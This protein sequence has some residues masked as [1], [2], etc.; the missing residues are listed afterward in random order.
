MLVGSAFKTR[1]QKVGSVTE[2]TTFSA[3]DF[4]A[5]DGWVATGLKLG[6]IN[7]FSYLQLLNLQNRGPQFYLGTL[8]SSWDL[9]TIIT[10]K[11]GLP[12]G[13]R[14]SSL[15]SEN[16]QIEQDHWLMRHCSMTSQ[17]KWR[18]CR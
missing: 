2:Q 11:K 9:R 4:S 17:S 6:A 7:S 12:D 8:Y 15:S 18:Q 10:L 1:E 5:G 13:L 3:R 14:V 16:K